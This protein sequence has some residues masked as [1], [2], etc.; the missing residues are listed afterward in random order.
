VFLGESTE[1]VLEV[2]GISMKCKVREEFPVGAA[3]FA[4]IDPRDVICLP[5]MEEQASYQVS[6]RQ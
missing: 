4:S 1:Y 2:G 6:A 5:E 3:V